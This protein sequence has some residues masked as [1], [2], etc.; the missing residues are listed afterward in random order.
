ML[1]KLENK[2]YLKNITSRINEEP[3]FGF[4]DLIDNIIKKRYELVKA[5]QFELLKSFNQNALNDMWRLYN[6]K[7][8]ENLQ[9]WNNYKNKIQAAII[10]LSEYLTDEKKDMVLDSIAEYLDQRFVYFDSVKNDHLNYYDSLIAFAKTFIPYPKYLKSLFKICSRWLKQDK[11]VVKVNAEQFSFVVNVLTKYKSESPQILDDFIYFYRREWPAIT[12][13]HDTTDNVF[14]LMSYFSEKQ[15]KPEIVIPALIDTLLPTYIKRYSSLFKV[16]STNHNKINTTTL[17]KNSNLMYNSIFAYKQKAMPVLCEIVGLGRKKNT[18]YSINKAY[19]IHSKLFSKP[20]EFGFK[21]INEIDDYCLKNKKQKEREIRKQEK[22]K[23]VPKI[24]QQAHVFFSNNEY[25]KALKSYKKALSL[26]SKNSEAIEGLEKTEAILIEKLS[27]EISNFLEK[28]H[29]L[30][31]IGNINESEKLLSDTRKLSLRIAALKKPI[32]DCKKLL[33]KK[34]KEIDEEIKKERIE[35]HEEIEKERIER[36][37]KINSLINEGKELF[38]NNQF[39]KSLQKYKQVLE[40]THYHSETLANIDKINERL[41]N[42]NKIQEIVKK[43]RS[44]IPTSILR[45]ADLAKT[46]EDEAKYILNLLINDR[47]VNGEILEIENVFIK[48]DKPKSELTKHYTCF[49]CGNPL[50]KEDANCFN[51]KKEVLHCSVCKLIIN[52]GEDAG[53][54]SLCESPAHMDHLQEWLKTQGKCPRCREKL[55]LEGIVPIKAVKGKK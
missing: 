22:L 46:S 3:G 44:E 24:V 55:P 37:I 42:K 51:C 54:C 7:P 23:Q 11:R 18:A 19:F 5:E 45:I 39:A 14:S 31:E 17:R 38:N 36:D 27:P 10:F 21:Y 30:I 34:K 50:N 15:L 47:F 48:Y 25:E 53:K 26:D 43:I 8:K 35:L 49:Y 9:N 33:N 29:E 28:V 20:N 1:K 52:F 41:S 12:F 13:Y 40:I 32:D 16:V 4:T 2:K 6:Y